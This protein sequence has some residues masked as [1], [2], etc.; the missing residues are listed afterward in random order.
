MRWSITLRPHVDCC[1]SSDRNPSRSR[2]SYA[3]VFTPQVLSALDAL[4]PLDGDRKAVMAARIARRAPR[5]RNRERIDVSRSG[6]DHRADHASRC[7]TRATA[8]LP[9]ARFP[10]ICSGSGFRA[11]VPAPSRSAPVEQSIRNV[12]LRAA[13]GRRRLDVRRRRR[14]RPGVDD[15][16]RQ[17]AQSEAGDPSRPG[18]PGGRRAGRGGNEPLGAG[19]SSAAPIIDDWQQPAR[20]HDQ[21]L[22]AARTASRRSSHP[23]RRRR[24]LLGVDR[25]RRAC[26]S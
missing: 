16:A 7:R 18:V 14:A 21:D 17:P 3:D 5:A 20:L 9:A 12:A 22:P 19:I 11:P 24:R 2:I 13:V 15:V 4:A 10:T 25:R 23:P 26:T 8:R 1:L 6:G